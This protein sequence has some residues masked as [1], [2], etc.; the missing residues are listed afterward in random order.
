MRSV[1]VNFS[2]STVPIDTNF[3]R[4]CQWAPT[5]LIQRSNGN[6]RAFLGFRLGTD[7]ILAK[8]IFF[9]TF[10][11]NWLGGSLQRVAW[12]AELDLRDAPVA[13]ALV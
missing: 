2:T 4:H 3:D 12:R 6:S 5:M 7:T 9:E 10:F 13:V 11:T 8:T 1:I